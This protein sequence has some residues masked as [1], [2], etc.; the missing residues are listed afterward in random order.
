MKLHLVVAAVV[1]AAGVFFGFDALR[2]C[3]LFFSIALVLTLEIVNTALE[4]VV[5]LISPE[6]RFLA[7]LVKDIAA[8]A[9]LVASLVACIIGYF[10]FFRMR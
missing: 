9:V 3:I 4:R 7:G 10:L 2:F 6:R 5:D 1:L 8:G